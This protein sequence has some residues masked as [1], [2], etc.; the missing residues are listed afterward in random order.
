MPGP[1]GRPAI[2]PAQPPARV[3]GVG[4]PGDPA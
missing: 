3:A 4:A 2:G 1:T